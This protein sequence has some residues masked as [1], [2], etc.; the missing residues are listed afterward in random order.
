MLLPQSNSQSSIR[1]VFVSVLLAAVAGMPLAARAQITSS[2]TLLKFGWV[3]VG[4]SETQVVTLT[5]T[6]TS[7]VTFSSVSVNG[8]EFNVAGAGLPRT[9]AA[10]NSVAVNV[11][12]APTTTGWVS[13]QVVFKSNASNPEL[14]VA[15]HGTGVGKEPVSA[16]PASLSFGS[17][18]VGSTAKLTVTL[19]NNCL[20]AEALTGLQ[21]VGGA[22]LVVD[23]PPPL[24]LDR[25]QS[26]T[27]TVSFTPQSAGVAGGSLM[28][29]GPWVNIPLEGA[30]VTS[31]VLN[32]PAS[33][34]FSNVVVGESGTETTT[35]SASGGNVTI[36]SASSSNSQFSMPGLSLPVTIA[37]GQS[38]PVQVTYT[39]TAAGS[40]SA[41]LTFISTA[42]TSRAVESVS[43]TAAMPYVSLSWSPSTSDVSG[44]NVYRGT[45]SS[46]PFTRLNGALNANTSYVD[47]TV[48]LSTKYY[49]A[50]TAVSSSGQESSYSNLVEVSVP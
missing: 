1:I 22:F 43:G 13:R 42:S 6:G 29:A 11:T 17:V 35:L 7:G 48:A 39:P 33:L 24:T 38:L 20:C 28:V 19:Q 49:Y 26:L 25:G 44:Y 12:F 14:V 5:N 23:P 4:Q 15:V 46:G 10:G 30:G 41:S 31:G 8:S 3:A 32:V 27:L 18:P 45:S 47:Q 40:A 36:T 37:A 16:S 2:V 9:L 21:M 34:S 50:T